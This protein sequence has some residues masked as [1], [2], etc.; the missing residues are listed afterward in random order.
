MQQTILVTGGFG[1]LG[2]AVTLKYKM[3]GHRVIGMGHS[4]W[5]TKQAL[6]FGYDVWVEASVSLTS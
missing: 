5:T 2:R 1:F 3:L 6:S 4:Q